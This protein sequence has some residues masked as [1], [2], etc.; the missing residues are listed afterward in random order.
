MYGILKNSSRSLFPNSSDSTAELSVDERI[1]NDSSRS[2]FPNSS[3]ST[4]N[5]SVDKEL[6]PNKTNN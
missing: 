6:N 4:A 2:L 1:L 5:L 3:D